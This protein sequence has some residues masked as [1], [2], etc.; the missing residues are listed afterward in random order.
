MEEWKH[1]EKKYYSIN[2]VQIYLGTEH[3]TPKQLAQYWY[4][5]FHRVEM[6][7]YKYTANKKKPSPQKGNPLISRGPA[8]LNKIYVK[9]IFF[10]S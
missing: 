2:K 4:N 10:L 5:D 8:I 1:G 6:K 3:N 7:E 9:N